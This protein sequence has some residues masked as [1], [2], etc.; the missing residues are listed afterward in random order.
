MSF[1][2]DVDRRSIPSYEAMQRA[3]SIATHAIPP[4]ETAYEKMLMNSIFPHYS[5]KTLLT[6]VPKK[7]QFTQPAQTQKNWKF[8]LEPSLSLGA[9]QFQ[10]D[11][12]HNNLDWG[13][14]FLGTNLDKVCYVF[15]VTSKD[16]SPCPK[17]EQPLSS[18][19]WNT[20]GNLLARGDEGSRLVFLDAIK[21]KAILDVK[22]FDGSG[23]FSMDWR[24]SFELALGTC[25]KIYGYD[26]RTNSIAWKRD[27]ESEEEKG[28]NKICSIRWHQGKSLL[29]TGSNTDRVHIYDIRMDSAQSL[30]S[31]S[32]K[33]AVKALCWLPNSSM[34][35]SG[36]GTTDRTV[37]VFDSV[38]GKQVCESH[39]LKLQ[40]T[41]IQCLDNR[42]FA[43]GLGYGP[44]PYVQ[45]PEGNMQFWEYNH[46]NRNLKKLSENNAQPGRILGIAKDPNSSELCSV[47]SDETLCFWK[48]EISAKKHK[49]I[50]LEKKKPFSSL[51]N[52]R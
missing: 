42:V 35:V 7:Q 14:Y 29:A 33:A 20:D 13:K 5:P 17:H 47:S 36:G 31:Y 16:I 45:P 39:Q 3:N 25:G 30:H 32:H 9:P 27:I 34:L 40:I 24:N 1:P 43:M 52:L 23:T 6:S 21:N 12:Y 41:S 49:N 26:L 11:F 18:L 38:L 8:P 19:K 48:P 4:P 15:N 28:R 37:K 44:H 46:E 2:S 51:L 22:S 50:I 10:D